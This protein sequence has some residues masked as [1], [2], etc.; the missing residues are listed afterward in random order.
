MGAL[1]RATKERLEASW[2]VM[3]AEASESARRAAAVTLDPAREA[4][5]AAT[6]AAREEQRLA[7]LAQMEAKANGES[8]VNAAR[9]DAKRQTEELWKEVH[10]ARQ[11]ADDAK[12]EAWMKTVELQALRETGTDP[13]AADGSSPRQRREETIEV[14]ALRTRVSEAEARALTLESQ[15]AERVS[16]T[17]SMTAEL[18]KARSEAEKDRDAAATTRGALAGAETERAALV[19]KLRAAENGEDVL[20]RAVRNVLETLSFEKEVPKRS[21]T[22]PS[23]EESETIPASEAKDPKDV[24]RGGGAVEEDP[25]AL[26]ARAERAAREAREKRAAAVER[27]DALEARLR[28][29]RE[30]HEL[31][32]IHISDPRD[33]G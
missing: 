24:A 13:D 7:R 20:T 15:L 4:L 11:S 17:Q 33:R 18:A 8:A 25:S 27:A 32:L 22:S 5:A 1:R 12:A 26:A 6:A 29:A 9:E 10:A 14:E 23:K 3:K 30:Q 2:E 31:S 19:K 16:E 21:E 28:S